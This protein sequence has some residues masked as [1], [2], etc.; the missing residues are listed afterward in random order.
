MPRLSDEFI[1]GRLGHLP[2]R[3]LLEGLE[4]DWCS[5]SLAVTQLEQVGGLS[6]G[7]EEITAGDEHGAKIRSAVAERAALSPEVSSD[8]ARWFILFLGRYLED[9][10]SF[11]LG[12]VPQATAH[13]ESRWFRRRDPVDEAADEY[14]GVPHVLWSHFDAPLDW[15]WMMPFF[16]PVGRS[17][18]PYAR[19]GRKM[20]RSEYLEYVLA[21][22]REDVPS[23]ERSLYLPPGE[24][25]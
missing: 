20:S 24:T 12:P 2:W 25:T 13:R 5:A 8:P 6:F 3:D 16:P 14:L 22:L 11:R 9:P 7:V 23:A 18:S 21:R 19:T 10:G 15:R 17:Q 4:H 1:R